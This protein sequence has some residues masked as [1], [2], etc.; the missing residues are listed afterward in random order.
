[1]GRVADNYNLNTLH[2]DMKWDVGGGVR[3]QVE[4][5]V[6]RAELAKGGEESTFRVMINQPF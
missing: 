6:V 3:F 5:V 1:M 4:G 2:D